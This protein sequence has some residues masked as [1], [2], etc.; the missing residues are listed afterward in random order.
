MATAVFFVFGL[1][2]GGLV[3]GLWMRARIARLEAAK[4]FSEQAGMQLGETFRALADAALRS[5]QSA[6]LDASRATLET[7]RAQISGELAQKQTAIEGVVRPLSESLDKLST[8][9][10]ELERARENAFG[11]LGEQLQ[12]LARETTALSTALRSPQARGRWGEITLRRVAELAGMVKNCD[13]LEQETFES[14]TARIRPDMIV[15]LPGERT[16]VVDAKVPLT[17]YL[18]AAAAKDEATR[19]AALQ[20]HGQQVA[21]HVRQ[22]SGKQYW[23]QFQPAPELVVLFLPGDHFFSAALEGN[24]QLIE[25]ALAQKVVIATP[26][27]LI[28][29]LRGIAYGWTQEQLAENAEEIRRVAAEL[30]Q[31]VQLVQGHYA[32]TGRLLERTVEAYNRSVGSWDTRLLPALRKMRELGVASGEEP[33][34]PEQ[35]DLLARRPRA[36]G[37]SF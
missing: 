19:R 36:V 16:L 33:E 29:V 15:R 22:L 34:A 28:A 14:G 10:R 1:L 21:E 18:D 25:D 12:A 3:V 24:P 37:G 20:R 5:N 27:T 4:Q 9:I 7:T 26:V 31:R 23:A 8:H 35:I 2:L 13:F 11:S 17:G 32:D 6:F 30:Y